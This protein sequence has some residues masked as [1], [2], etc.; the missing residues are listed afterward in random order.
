MT[1]LNA[2]GMLCKASHLT[3]SAFNMNIERFLKDIPRLKQPREKGE[4][5]QKKPLFIFSLHFIAAFIGKLTT[6]SQLVGQLN[7][8]QLTDRA[9]LW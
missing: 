4:P 2:S 5:T 1:G 9:A 6:A 7:G 8:S 3:L